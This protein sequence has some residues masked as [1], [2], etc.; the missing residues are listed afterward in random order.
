MEQAATI[1]RWEQKIIAEVCGRFLIN[2]SRLLHFPKRKN[3]NPKNHTFIKIANF[4]TSY[5][6]Y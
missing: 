1:V 4:E 5:N 6:Q 2:L 3:N